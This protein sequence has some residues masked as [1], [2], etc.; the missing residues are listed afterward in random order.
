METP[1]C[2]TLRNLHN[3]ILNL[4]QTLFK[5]FSLTRVRILIFKIVVLLTGLLHLQPFY[6]FPSENIYEISFLYIQILLNSVTAALH[7]SLRTASFYF[8]NF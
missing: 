1:L 6:I 4:I 3:R 2:K 7:F 5:L 8:Y